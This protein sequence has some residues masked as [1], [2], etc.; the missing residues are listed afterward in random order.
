MIPIISLCQKNVYQMEKIYHLNKWSNASGSIVMKNDKNGGIITF[1]NY[2][3]F[4]TYTTKE[5][6]DLSK[7]SGEWKSRTYVS[8]VKTVVELTI[9]MEKKD[10]KYYF[11]VIYPN[12]K[13]AEEFITYKKL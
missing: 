3:E 10:N 4:I 6:I 5:P 7:D 9:K 11:K 1:S 13:P 8:E 12:N 2:N